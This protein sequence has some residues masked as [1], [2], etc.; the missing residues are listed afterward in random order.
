MPEFGV[1][2]VFKQSGRRSSH[3]TSKTDT[4]HLGLSCSLITSALSH[5]KHV[6]LLSGSRSLRR[7]SSRR[8]S[9]CFVAAEREHSTHNREKRLPLILSD[10]GVSNG[11]GYS[12]TDC[13]CASPTES[14]IGI[15][16]RDKS[17]ITAVS[18]SLFHL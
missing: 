5:C 6:I 9:F 11:R 18:D 2:R 3:V 4:R 7:N 15:L 8:Q 14:E 12:Q 10:P 13:G 1:V 16:E 17:D